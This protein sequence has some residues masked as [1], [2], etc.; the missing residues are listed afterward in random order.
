M[1]PFSGMKIGAHAFDLKINDYVS[2]ILLKTNELMML[3]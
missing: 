1:I 2:L 3:H